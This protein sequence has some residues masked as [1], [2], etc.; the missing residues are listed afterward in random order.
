MVSPSIQTFYRKETSPSPPKPSK[1]Q[2]ISKTQND[3]F[4]SAEI[5]ATLRPLTR[6]W[7]PKGVHEYVTIDQLQAG[8][9]RI[10]LLAT[11][12]EHDC[13]RFG[14][15]VTVWASF[16]AEYTAA[17][18]IRVPY[19]SAIVPVHPSLS[20]TSCIKFH[21]DEA[22][23]S[24]EYRLCRRPL[25]Y[26]D[27][28]AAVGGSSQ[29][30]PSS[31]FPST[32]DYLMSLKAYIHSGHEGVPSVKI[33][34]CVSSVGPR[35]VVKSSSSDKTTTQGG[36]ELEMVE[37]R[38]F[39]ETSGCVLLLWEDKVAS[40]RTWIPN[41]TILLITNPRFRPP[42][43]NKKNATAPEL[44][45]GF[46]SLV[47]V[48][49]AFPD[50]DWLRRMAVGRTKRESVYIPFP[51]S[52]WDAEVA[53]KG[54]DHQVLFTLA[55]LDNFVRDDPDA[56][57]T[58]KLNL[59]ILGVRIMENSRANS[60]CITECCGVPLS[61][62][63]PRATCKNCRMERVLTLNPRIIGCLVD[64]TGSIAM[65]KLIWSDRAWTELFFG[66]P[67]DAGDADQKNGAENSWEELTGLDTN[68]LRSVEEHLQFSRVTLTFGWSSVVGR[69]CVLGVEW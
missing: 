40:A 21:H 29:Q 53:I 48:D 8:P 58:G 47:E 44:S 39:D 19:V 1:M 65:G 38:I 36:M 51:A 10:K 63:R 12:I 32:P 69:L 11:G 57:F 14:V 7:K 35:K 27:T 54:P 30:Q 59:V 52:I 46:T 6:A 55:D 50:A 60:L 23:D 9:C 67:S 5:A 43:N 28:A 66:D 45:I 15:R 20:S 24:E 61:A 49:P 26:G 4:T 16:V 68:A 33:L 22:P 41:Q 34:V 2:H 17:S 56:I 42:I 37:V 13:L 62:N 18:A 64:E 31:Y 25:D 3:G